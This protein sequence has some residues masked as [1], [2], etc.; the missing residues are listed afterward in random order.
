MA[1][2][3][4]TPREKRK[5]RIRKRIQGTPERPRL[6]IFRSNR[7]LYAQVIDDLTQKTLAS[8]SSLKE[9]KAANKSAAKIVGKA[10]AEKALE[11]KIESVVFDRNGYLYHGVIKELADSAREAGL[12]F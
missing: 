9:G 3:K 11:N 6:T 10:I 8:A 1:H 7:Y 5:I 12:K 2:K 4:V